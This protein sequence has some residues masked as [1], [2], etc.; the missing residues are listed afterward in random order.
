[1]DGHFERVLGAPAA[2]RTASAESAP[3]P[4]RSRLSAEASVA[5]INALVDGARAQEGD[6]LDAK[7]LKTMAKSLQKQVRRNALAREKHAAEPA[8]FLQSELE[9]DEQL[10]RWRQVAAHP[11]LFA[12]MME[13]QV[14]RALLALMAHDNLD[15]RLAV[16]SLLSDLTDVDEAAASLEPAR[17][18]AAHLMDEKLLS[19]LVSN[20]YQLAAAVDAA[21]TPEQAQEEA[22]GL[23]NSLQIL[24]NLADLEPDVCVQVA[25]DTAVLPFLLEQVAAR[26]PFSDNKLYAS[27]IL[28][29]LLQSGAAPREKFVAWQG[30]PRPEEEKRKDKNDAKV[31]LMDELLQ[32]LAP[33]RKKDPASDEE[34]E[35]VSNLVNAL[36]SVLLVPEA[37]KQFRRLE[38]LELLLRFMKDRQRFVFGGALRAM[39]HALMGN[40]RNCERLIEIG[41]LRSVFLAFMGRHGKYK[42]SSSTKASKASERAKEEENAASLVASLCAWVGVKAPADGYDRLHAKFVESDMEKV[43]RLVDLFAKHHERVERSRQ[44]G[45]EDEDEDEDSRYLRRLDAGLFVLERIAFVVAHLCRFSKKL[46]AYVMVKFHER[47][48]ESESLVA[49]LREQLDVLVADAAVE[50]EDDKANSKDAND[51][52]NDETREAQKEQLRQLLET[53]KA[54][55]APL[56]EVTNGSSEKANQS[57]DATKLE[58]AKVEIEDKPDS[59]TKAAVSSS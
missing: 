14:P 55:E 13:L 36:C 40:A 33:Y 52:V 5:R 57:D 18:L 47:S 6:Q 1:M 35:F 38:G 49:V 44:L 17:N 19:L 45:D 22:T 56:P 34:E 53:L 10:T 21:D 31:D 58:E 16:L 46:K 11:E 51:L 48:I 39:D 12:A 41:G 3:A 54:E 20:L 2:K 29:I 4:K 7:V 15:I 9:L 43:D 24:E 25:K 37:Q 23:Y 27:E 8:K 50:N 28:S 32:A 59:E 26:R 42:S 30:K